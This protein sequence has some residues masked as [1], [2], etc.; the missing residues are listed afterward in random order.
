[1]IPKVIDGED[2]AL[3]PVGKRLEETGDMPVEDVEFLAGAE[4]LVLGELVMAAV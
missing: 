2:R 3:P 1:M 4:L